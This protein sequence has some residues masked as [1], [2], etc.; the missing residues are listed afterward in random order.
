MRIVTSHQGRLQIA[1][2]GNAV[3]SASCGSLLALEAGHVH[4]L[5]VED[6]TPRAV[7]AWLSG[8]T[9]QAGAIVWCEPRSGPYPP[10]LSLAG[11]RTRGVY[12]LCPQT[13]ADAYWA[14]TESLRCRGVAV[15]VAVAARLTPVQARRFQLAAERGGGLG[16]L[17]RPVAHAQEHAART[18]WLVQP[19]RG[20]PLVQRWRL[21]LIHGPG[22]PADE[23]FVL[24]VSRETHHVRAT[25]LLADRPRQATPAVAAG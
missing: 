1:D 17:I 18:R 22:R 9:R 15:T 7:A 5:L 10:A 20:D 12:R 8:S 2:G 16:L 13:D 21:R 14:V 24:E 3:L 23:E 4:E 11:V 6:I 25:R 19:E